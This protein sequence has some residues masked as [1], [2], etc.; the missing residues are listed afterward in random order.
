VFFITDPTVNFV[1]EISDVTSDQTIILDQFSLA[2]VNEDTVAD[3]KSYVQMNAIY[4]PGPNTV[5]SLSLQSCSLSSL[6]TYLQSVGFVCFNPSITIPGTIF[7][8]LFND[9]SMNFTVTISDCIDFLNS[10][11]VSMY[12]ILPNNFEVSLGNRSFVNKTGDYFVEQVR[13]KPPMR[14]Y[15][16]LD[17][18]IQTYWISADYLIRWQ[19]TNRTRYR[20]TNVRSSYIQEDISCTNGE[21]MV[22]VVE[23]FIDSELVTTYVNY[24]TI[25]TLFSQLGALYTTLIMVFGLLFVWLNKRKT[26]NVATATEVKKEL[27]P[28]EYLGWPVQ[29]N[30][31]NSPTKNITNNTRSEK[32][33]PEIERAKEPIQ[34]QPVEPES[35]KLI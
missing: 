16:Q 21:S 23:L 19:K 2:I 31:D 27:N 9:R 4:S 18:Q 29:I 28:G 25:V 10:L 22:A 3:V 8:Q 35:K 5:Q 7:S 1:E 13:L 32:V 20:V 26:M 33:I 34:V 14:L 30:E 6:P 24:Q 17:V 12:F 15:L 11:P